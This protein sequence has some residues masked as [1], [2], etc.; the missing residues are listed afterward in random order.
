MSYN[1]NYHDPPYGPPSGAAPSY[2]TSGTS[3]VGPSHHPY[4]HQPPLDSDTVPMSIPSPHPTGTAS[5]QSVQDGQLRQHARDED[6]GDLSTQSSRPVYGYEYD[7]AYEGPSQSQPHS[8]K[9][10]PSSVGPWDSASQRDVPI[11]D[12]AGSVPRPYTHQALSDTPSRHIPNKPSYAGG[13]SYIDEEGAYYRSDSQR[14]A[15]AYKHDDV[16]MRG[17]MSD[18][19]E[20]GGQESGNKI[21]FTEYETSPMPYPAPDLDK[22]Q[23]YGEP[24]HV[25]N[26]L[27][28]P[29]GLDRLLA[30]FGVSVG[31]S[32]PEQAAERKRR[33]VPGQRWPVAAWTLTAGTS[34]TTAGSSEPV[35]DAD[36]SHVWYHGIRACE[37]SLPHG[38]RH[39]DKAHF[40]L[41]DRTV[42]L[43]AHQHRRE[44]PSVS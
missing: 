10:A 34:Y 17:L 1:N 15:S 19:G 36:T 4:P 14:P 24:S 35:P 26:W 37:E 5:A 3:F 11:G 44:V 38:Q 16:E 39:R 22:G 9:R 41:H 27:L 32:P 30:L 21:K 40:Q 43:C 23:S 7:N 42:S 2:H 28:F 8:L 20:M 29:T 6:L 18:P 25:Y 12:D 13:L 33:G 31:S